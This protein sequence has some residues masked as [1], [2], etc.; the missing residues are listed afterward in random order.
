MARLQSTQKPTTLL[1]LKKDKDESNS[2]MTFKSGE[3][4]LITE[5][6]IVDGDVRFTKGDKALYGNMNGTFPLYPVGSIIFFAGSEQPDGYLTCNGQQVSRHLYPEL[7]D[8]IRYTWGKGISPMTGNRHDDYFRVP[9]FE[10]AANVA[11]GVSTEY[12]YHMSKSSDYPYPSINDRRIHNS[13]P[14][15]HYISGLFIR[16]LNERGIGANIDGPDYYRLHVTK[17]G[18]WDTRIASGNNREL[19]ERQFGPSDVQMDL[20]Q[21][22]RHK[23][24]STNTTYDGDHNHRYYGAPRSRYYVKDDGTINT[25]VGDNGYGRKLGS[26][27]DNS[28]SGYFVN[29]GIYSKTVPLAFNTATTQS[30]GAHIHYGFAGYGRNFADQLNTTNVNRSD[31]GHLDNA[32]ETRPKNYSVMFCIKY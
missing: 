11:D 30:S 23:P 6:G 18:L 25:R 14:E 21:R 19:V 3:I 12:I 32:R 9:D 2:Y 15:E 7:F 31:Q 10:N 4:I 27:E 5:Q 13:N 26:Y 8:K 1:T 24:V 16:N 20:F 17:L 28:T 29:F 22:H